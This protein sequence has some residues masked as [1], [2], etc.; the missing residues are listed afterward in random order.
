MLVSTFLLERLRQSQESV[1][2]VNTKHIVTHLSSRWRRFADHFNTFEQA[3][4]KRC[5][6]WSLRWFNVCCHLFESTGRRQNI[7]EHITPLH[8]P[9]RARACVH[10]GV[11]FTNIPSH[12]G[13]VKAVNLSHELHYR[14]P[15]LIL[16]IQEDLIPRLPP[17][18][19]TT[20][21]NMIVLEGICQRVVQSPHQAARVE[22]EAV[23]VWVHHTPKTFHRERSRMFTSFP[24]CHFIIYSCPRS[25]RM[26]QYGVEM[27]QMLQ[28][29]RL[30]RICSV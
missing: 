26:I 18:S 9:H 3:K 30:C 27:W 8:S 15:R 28:K 16:A 10:V 19:L 13:H 1:K 4:F 17:V 20:E 12:R 7:T 25:N 5:L 2:I 22:T 24:H 11:C 21:Q 29:D 14:I 23:L 6:V